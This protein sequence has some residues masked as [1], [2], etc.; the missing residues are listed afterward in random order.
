ADSVVDK[1]AK[2]CAQSIEIA[3]YPGRFIAVDSDI[4]VLGLRDGSMVGDRLPCQLSQFHRYRHRF[5]EFRL[6]PGEREQLLDEVV[7]AIHTLAQLR[8][9]GRP[10]LGGRR[11]FGEL[12]LQL[13]GSKRGT[14]FMSGIGNERTAQVQRMA[15]ACEQTVQSG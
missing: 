15:E 11:A 4:D 13:N 1:I 12:D 2:H 14:Q 5:R 8:E 9:R 7:C 3:R 6:M 10:L